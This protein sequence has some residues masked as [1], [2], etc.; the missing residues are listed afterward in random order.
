M[1]KIFAILL[2]MAMIFGLAACG[3][4]AGTTGTVS[5][6]QKSDANVSAKEE[7]NSQETDK[8]TENNSDSTED[9][10][11][12]PEDNKNGTDTKSD[13]STDKNSDKNTD[14]VSENAKKVLVVYYSAT[15]NTKE[16]AEEIATQTKGELFELKPVEEYSDADLDY[17]D[18]ESRVCKEHVTERLQDVELTETTTEAFQDADVVF[19]GY[20][21]WWSQA[22]WPVNNF[23][24]NN[25]FTGKTVIPFCTSAS[26]DIGNSSSQLQK[27]AGTGVWQFGKRFSSNVSSDDVKNWVE[28]LELDK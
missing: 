1:K 26:S 14:T 21:I 16:V 20:P 6:S 18:P 4:S 28:S 19:L 25:D 8:K 13:T 11:T 3:N 2:S 10:A 5:D 15:G 17:N 24:K 9:P 12:Q 7:N 23:V 22:A 27:M